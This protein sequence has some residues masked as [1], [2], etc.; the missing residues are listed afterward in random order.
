MVVAHSAPVVLGLNTSGTYG[1]H[2][3]RRHWCAGNPNRGYHNLGYVGAV[4]VILALVTAEAATL[5][6]T[7]PTASRTTTSWLRRDRSASF[8]VANFAA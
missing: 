1:H 8:W 6:I 3:R 2:S 7:A 5:K 4:F